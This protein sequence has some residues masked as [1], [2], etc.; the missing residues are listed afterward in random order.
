MDIRPNHT[1]YINN[2]NDKIKK[3]GKN[4][5][6]SLIQDHVASYSVPSELDSNLSS[7][8]GAVLRLHICI[9]LCRWSIS[10]NSEVTCVVVAF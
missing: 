8:T 4:H 2:V 1:I 5:S 9:C 6:A 3:D 10:N 7:C